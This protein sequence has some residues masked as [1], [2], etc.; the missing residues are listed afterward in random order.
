MTR[1]NSG[2]DASV[3]HSYF[4]G[5]HRKRYSHCRGVEVYFLPLETGSPHVAQAA[6][7]LLSSSEPLAG[8]TG[9]CYSE[10]LS[11]SYKHETEHATTI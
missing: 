3:D 7:E 2:Q 1:Q 11:V 10:S 6:L 4:A 5:G 9:M 8:T